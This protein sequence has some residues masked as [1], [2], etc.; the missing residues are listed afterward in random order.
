MVFL[1]PIAI[2]C[3]WQIPDA[4]S[5][6]P[7]SKFTKAIQFLSEKHKV[8]IIAD[9]YAGLTFSVDPKSL[10]EVSLNAALKNLCT[11]NKYISE[12]SNGVYL[13]RRQNGAGIR[14]EESKPGYPFAWQREGKAQV[15]LPKGLESLIAD[16]PEY[17]IETTA[18]SLQMLGR[19][20][21][22]AGH[23]VRISPEIATQ[24]V[25]VCAP[26]I[27]IPTLMEAVGRLFNA[28]PEINLKRSPRQATRENFEG[29]NLP[30]DLVARRTLS[31]ELMG[32]VLDSLTPQQKKARER[33]EFLEMKLSTLPEKLRER[34]SLYVRFS[35]DV[36]SK[37]LDSLGTPDWSKLDRFEISLK[38]PGTPGEQTIGVGV[39]RTDGSYIVF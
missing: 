8:A 3:T 15:F 26:Q 17:G 4:P 12:F 21:T 28:T 30:P 19:E 6:V 22:K 14:Q 35:F 9:T 20:L 27:R 11:A 36:S 33:G 39:L 2:L 24:R 32:D 5:V 29:Q 25:V 34:L 18:V 13:L 37:E 38:P 10:S 7:E 16:L 23:P 1:T 31:A